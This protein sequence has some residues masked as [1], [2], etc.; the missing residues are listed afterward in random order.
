MCDLWTEAP[1]KWLSKTP[2]LVYL[3]ENIRRFRI[4]SLAC[5]TFCLV[6]YASPVRKIAWTLLHKLVSTSPPSAQSYPSLPPLLATFKLVYSYIIFSL[7]MFLWATFPLLLHHP[8]N[9]T[10]L[11]PSSF[12][13]SFFF[14]QLSFSP[15]NRNHFSGSLKLHYLIISSRF[16]LTFLV[17]FHAHSRRRYR[18]LAHSACLFVYLSVSAWHRHSDGLWGCLFPPAWQERRPSA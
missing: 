16:S 9:S 18:S 6:N 17:S 1:L 13:F 8:D 10:L 4:R 2:L 5:V 15:G 3:S 7:S 11:L 14:S 12:F